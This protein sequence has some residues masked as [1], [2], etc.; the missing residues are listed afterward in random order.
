MK[1]VVAAQPRRSRPRAEEREE[2]NQTRDRPEPV[3]QR[4][5]DQRDHQDRHRRPHPL[6]AHLYRVVRRTLDG[7]RTVRRRFFTA[8]VAE[9][10][11]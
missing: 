1:L 5:Q 3:N 11:P 4:D 8:A 10:Y 9:T 6:A 2:Y 7:R